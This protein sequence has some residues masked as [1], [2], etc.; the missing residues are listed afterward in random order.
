MC[1]SKNEKIA[2]EVV[3]AYIDEVGCLIGK[4]LKNPLKQWGRIKK[5]TVHKCS[6]TARGLT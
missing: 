2:T 5:S 3:E 6:Y 4:I 1:P